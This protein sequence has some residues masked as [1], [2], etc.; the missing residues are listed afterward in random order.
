VVVEANGVGSVQERLYE[1]WAETVASGSTFPSEVTLSE[2]L[3]VSRTQ[4]REAL[5]RMEE[6]GMI[7]RRHGADTVVNPWLN[8][9]EGRLDRRADF[10]ETIARA[11]MTPDLEVLE[12]GVAV[13][14][15]EDAADFDVPEGSSAWRTVKRWRGDGR[16]LMVAT[17]LVPLHGVVLSPLPTESTSLFELVE[18][19]FG[20]PLEWE[21][22][23]PGACS[24]DRVDAARLEL[25]P[26]A[27]AMTLDLLGIGRSGRVIYK[28]LELHVPGAVR[29][30]FV[31][32]GG[33]L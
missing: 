20:T 30:G 16:T 32:P 21:I 19:L 18:R 24:L 22:A 31:R 11:G 6:R 12:T 23:V 26:G 7:R 13:L 33:V 8:R 28:A 4:L 10:S 3:G 2:R 17:D 29:S 1:V 25:E 15:A 27:A 5:V 14:D 9:L